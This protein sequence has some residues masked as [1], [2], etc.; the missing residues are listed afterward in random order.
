MNNFRKVLL[1]GAEDEFT[2]QLS[3]RLLQFGVQIDHFDFNNSS[4]RIAG[5][6]Q[7]QYDSGGY[8][9]FIKRFWY[10]FLIIRFIPSNYDY[11]HYFFIKYE[12]LLL[13]PL[14]N[15]K[16][17]KI[18]A[19]VF[20]SDFNVNP[21]RGTFY[22]FFRECHKIFFS[23][24]ELKREFAACYSLFPETKYVVQH[25]GIGLLDTIKQ[26]IPLYSPAK[27]EYVITIGSSASLVEQHEKIIEEILKWEDGRKYQLKFVIPLTYGGYATDE[28]KTQLQTLAR[29]YK[30]E[31]LT[32]YLSLEKLALI[33]L[34][35]DIFI[36]LRKSD[37][38]SAALV[39]YVYSGAAV[40][41]GS[42]LPYKFFKQIG[43]ELIQVDS[44]SG[45]IPQLS[46]TLSNLPVLKSKA[47]LNRDI[48]YSTFSWDSVQRKWTELYQ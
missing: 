10:A 28:L 31:I 41:T 38:L 34:Q 30:V 16:G 14:L 32:E 43:I 37:Q 4:L 23:N 47:M 27:A 42:W 12:Y 40:I 17:K 26:A 11:L 29:S 33:R 6:I 7:K 24:P 44:I 46:Y 35:T 18:Y 39:E 25:F 36:S 22:L 9:H 1:I 21:I 3:A 5:V 48:I 19:Y 2:R 13:Y 8:F 15:R 20:G 45:L